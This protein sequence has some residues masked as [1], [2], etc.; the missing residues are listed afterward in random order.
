[1]GA[2]MT[3]QPIIA[4]SEGEATALARAVVGLSEHYN[5]QMDSPY[6]AIVTLVGVAGMI[7]VP[8]VKA[9]M[10]M[11]KANNVNRAEQPADPLG[12]AMHAAQAQYD[13]SKA[14]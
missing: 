5:L 2:M 8:R 4:L 11:R 3:G 6:F 1:M 7:Y 13:L 14:A 12:A 10:A 9:V